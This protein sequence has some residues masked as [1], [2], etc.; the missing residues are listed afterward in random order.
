MIKSDAALANALQHEFQQQ[1]IYTA[2]DTS[3]A[4]QVQNEFDRDKED[5]PP[6]D[7]AD[8]E[9]L[10]RRLQEEENRR[11]QEWSAR[12]YDLHQEQLRSRRQAE[13]E[14]SGSGQNV[15]DEE[16]A[17]RLVL[18]DRP[19]FAPF[20]PREDPH[21]I[22][23]TSSNDLHHGGYSSDNQFGAGNYDN[24]APSGLHGA[25]QRV[26]TYEGEEG[27]GAEPPTRESRYEPVEQIDDIPCDLCSEAIPFNRY[28]D[29]LVRARRGANSNL[30][31]ETLQALG[32][33]H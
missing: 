26:D 27:Q 22:N 23:L 5:I 10:A 11:I 21:D 9:A 29:H 6:E 8:D 7:T 32:E 15:T 17:R 30:T 12:Q 25:Q 31:P 13:M 2:H 18:E 3:I 1:D 4:Q 28:N 33:L 24:Y 16:L 14:A 19:N 20:H